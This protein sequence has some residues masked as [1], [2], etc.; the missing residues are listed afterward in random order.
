MRDLV[1]RLSTPEFWADFALACAIMV[2]PFVAFY[3]YN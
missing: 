3:A 2:T 1:N